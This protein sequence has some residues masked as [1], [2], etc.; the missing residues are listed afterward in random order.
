[1]LHIEVMQMIEEKITA[2]GHTLPEALPTKHA[3]SSVLIHDGIA[4]VSGT[5]PYV[6]GK[7]PQTG[8]CGKE[9]TIEEGKRLAEICILNA[10]AALKNE[11]GD[12]RKIKQFIKVTGFISSADDFT[13]QGAVL[14]G[15]TELL[16]NV[17]G[18]QGKHARSGVGTP[19]MPGG[20]PVEIECI[21]A[22]DA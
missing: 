10:L 20:T 21:V 17:F 6:D 18:D 8:Q 13:Q 4:Y 3:F 11:L 1:M 14:N 9:V 16:I 7:L 22:V 12:L 19:V 5:L 2:L 15:A